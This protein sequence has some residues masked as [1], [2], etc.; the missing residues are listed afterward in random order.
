M[1]LLKA[2]GRIGARGAEVVVV[3]ARPGWCAMTATGRVRVHSVSILHPD[4]DTE[5][6]IPESE[7]AALRAEVKRLREGIVADLAPIRELHKPSGDD[8]RCCI[9]CIECE[10]LWPCATA[11][12]IYTSEELQ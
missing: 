6:L 4:G 3:A 9:H 7:V 11:R 1:R 8:C 2:G 10:Q 5:V 12:L